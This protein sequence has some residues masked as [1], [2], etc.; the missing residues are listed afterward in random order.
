MRNLNHTVG[1][2]ASEIQE[3][4]K[5]VYLDG[6]EAGRNAGRKEMAEEVR[7][8]FAAMLDVGSD[9]VMDGVSP[10]DDGQSGGRAAPGTVKP[11]V[12][13][14]IKSSAEGMTTAEIR[15]A[16]GFKPN[17]IR[18]TL[19]ALNTQDK[20]IEQNGD[21]WVVRNNSA[22]KGATNVPPADMKHFE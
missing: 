7:N 16:T 14:L 10:E 3:L 1:E 20:L 11:A 12:L 2:A 5:I 19:W 18:G 17:S 13:S 4:L 9:A 22:G 8:K 15:T 21:R 6:Y